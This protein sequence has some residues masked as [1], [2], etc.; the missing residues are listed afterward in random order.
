MGLGAG[1]GVWI[2]VP[3]GGSL[4]HVMAATPVVDPERQVAGGWDVWGYNKWGL[5]A[6]VR[7]VAGQWYASGDLLVCMGLLI[8]LEEVHEAV[9][10]AA[11]V[12]PE[13]SGR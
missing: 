11:D 1:F 7:Y 6:L 13:G 2:N 8:H 10:G 9:K 3:G 5:V 12:V 4:L